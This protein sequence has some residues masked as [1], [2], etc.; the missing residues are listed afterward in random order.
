[1]QA[2]R[3]A[4]FVTGL[5][6]SQYFMRHSAVNY[7][8]RFYPNEEEDLMCDSGKYFY[9]LV[10]ITNYYGP[11]E[12]EEGQIYHYGEEGEDIGNNQS[13]N[14]N[15]FTTQKEYEG[16]NTGNLNNSGTLRGKNKNIRGGNKVGN[17][18]KVGAKG[19][20]NNVNNNANNNN[21][22]GGIGGMSEEEMSNQ[23]MGQ[24]RSNYK[25]DNITCTHSWKGNEEIPEIGVKS[26]VANVKFVWENGRRK[27]ITTTVRTMINGEVNTEI[28]KEDA[29]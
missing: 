10:G 5:D 25:E 22:I 7:K 24:K 18:N 1:M 12:N 4:Q 15:G 13:G 20:K 3:G 8:D 17:K 16:D 23:L 14:I 21:N 9:K 11:K 2:D 29:F 28:T 6:N 26:A 19:G 27:K